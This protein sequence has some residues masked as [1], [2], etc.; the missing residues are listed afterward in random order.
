MIFFSKTL[1]EFNNLAPIFANEGY[2]TCFIFI[3]IDEYQNINKI[4]K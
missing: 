3:N 4:N 1:A 2:K